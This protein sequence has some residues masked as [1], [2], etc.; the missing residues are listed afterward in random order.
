MS[1][2]EHDR[3]RPGATGWTE[4]AGPARGDAYDDRWR[5]LEAEGRSVHGEADLVSALLPATP[6]GDG[7]ARVLDAGCGTGRVAVELAARGHDVVGVDRDPDL[8]AAAR[9]KAPDLAWV[10]AD[11]AALGGTVAPG[12]VD[13][14]VLAGNVLLFTDP[15]TEA[16]VVAQVAS[17]LRPRGLLVAGFQLV[18]GRVTVDGLD[19]HAAAA[20][21]ELVDRWSTWEREPFG[22]ADRYQVSVHRRSPA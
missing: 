13:L 2:A 5:R 11:L 6:A 20:G 10:E 1:P 17:A 22:P 18:P 8:L 7:P 16:R 14:A 15:G 12:T 4:L 3:R 19:A 9:R 21:L